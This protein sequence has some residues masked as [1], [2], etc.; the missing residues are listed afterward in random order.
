M[1]VDAEVLT[2]FVVSH[3][4]PVFQRKAARISGILRCEYCGRGAY[5]SEGLTCK[6][7]G[8]PLP[9][10]EVPSA[11]V[12]LVD[13]N[14]HDEAFTRALGIPGA[15][16]PIKF[17]VKPSKRSRWSEFIDGAA[18]VAVVMFGR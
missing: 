7:C 8:G 18:G 9:V 11:P 14:L 15:H 12:Y 5:L 10:E 6:G 2:D 4:W 16:I 17:P 3:T 1:S 13:S